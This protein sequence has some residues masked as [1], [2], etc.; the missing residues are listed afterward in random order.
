MISKMISI[1]NTPTSTLALLLLLLLLSHH[2][3]LF[4]TTSANPATTAT[5][6]QCHLDCR[7]QPAPHRRPLR[8]KPWDERDNRG[9]ELGLTRPHPY[10]PAGTEMV[11]LRVEVTLRLRAPRFRE[12]LHQFG[13]A[14]GEVV[15]EA[16]RRVLEEEYFYESLSVRV[17]GDAERGMLLEVIN[18]NGEDVSYSDWSLEME[19][20]VDHN[21]YNRSSIVEFFD[22]FIKDVTAASGEEGAKEEG[23]FTSVVRELSLNVERL[24]DATLTILPPYPSDYI[25]STVLDTALNPNPFAPFCELGCTTFFSTTDHPITIRSCFD[26]CDATFRYETTVGYND[27]MELSRLECRDGCEMALARCQPGYYCSRTEMTVCPPGTY[28]DVSYEAV[29]SCVPCPPGRF[30]EDVKG[31][32]LE[33]GC[34]KCPV[35]TYAAGEGSTSVR[36]CLRCPAGTYNAE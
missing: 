32:S 12:E 34:T 6:D 15:P 19:C 5:E 22:K 29:S 25:T 33:G 30:R 14:E 9:N 24:E 28:R 27:V 35:G 16:V 21:G 18:G 11:L 26:V 31:R 36:D 20:I 8:T 10:F 4:P 23:L 13:D 1:H 7:G 3:T 2:T 17:L